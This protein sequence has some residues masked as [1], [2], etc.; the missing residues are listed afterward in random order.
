MTYE[1][2]ASYDSTPTC[3]NQQSV[4]KG[5][6]AFVHGVEHILQHVEILQSQ[7]CSHDLTLFYSH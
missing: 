5:A 4:G 2:K 3:K 1:D 6:I 7:L